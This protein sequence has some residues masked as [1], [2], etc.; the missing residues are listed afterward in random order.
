MTLSERAQKAFAHSKD[1]Q[2]IREYNARLQEQERKS[3][4]AAEA[5]KVDDPFPRKRIQIV[6]QELINRRN[7]LQFNRE[8]AEI[9]KSFEL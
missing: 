6:S 3:K 7:E 4:I 2:R 5:R 8:L 9:N 1:K